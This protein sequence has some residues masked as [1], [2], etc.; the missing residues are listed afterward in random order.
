M[1]FS[2][3]ETTPFLLHYDPTVTVPCSLASALM[4]IFLLTSDQTLAVLCI[5][6]LAYLCRSTIRDCSSGATF[7]TKGTMIRNPDEDSQGWYGSVGSICIS[8]LVAGLYSTNDVD[9]NLH[10]GLASRWCNTPVQCEL[11]SQTYPCVISKL[12]AGAYETLGAL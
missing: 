5:G 6:L 1:S 3:Y 10:G 8:W 9:V 7:Y 2:C 11:D 4:A 12:I